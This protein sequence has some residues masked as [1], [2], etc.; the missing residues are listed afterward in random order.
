M[1]RGPTIALVAFFGNLAQ[2]DFQIVN[3]FQ[4]GGRY[5]LAVKQQYITCDT[6]NTYSGNDIQ[7]IDV[8]DGSTVVSQF[9]ATPFTVQAGLC[10]QGLPIDFY[11]VG[12]DS[13]NDNPSSYSGYFAGGDGSQIATCYPTGV[14]DGQGLRCDENDT[15]YDQ[16]LYCY[17]YVCSDPPPQPS[18]TPPPPSGNS[19]PDPGNG[20]GGSAGDG[21]NTAGSSGDGSSG[22][23][24]SNGGNSS[25]GGSSGG[26]G[27]SSGGGSDG[28][29]TGG[30]SSGGDGGGS[31][32]GGGGSSG[33][34]DGGSSGGGSS[35]GSS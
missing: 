18:A 2:A 27:G 22:G 31:S 26:G 17:S 6:F 23:G 7:S 8:H 11:P 35:G 12:Q 24:S 5:N 9:Y 15:E 10:E 19:G 29:S 4:P 16:I 28:G 25:G 21:S 33:G 20:N 14:Q 1:I 34:G 32:G 3:K 30:G 13:N